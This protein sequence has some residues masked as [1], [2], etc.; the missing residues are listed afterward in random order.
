[1]YT[2]RYASLL[3]IYTYTYTNAHKEQRMTRDLCNMRCYVRAIYGNK[4]DTM[5]QRDA[6]SKKFERKNV[7]CDL[8][9]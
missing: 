2:Y 3:S 9:N 4:I 1:M 5:S 7:S 8:S 6:F